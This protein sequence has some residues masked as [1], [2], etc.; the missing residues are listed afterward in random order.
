MF[1]KLTIVCS[2]ALVFISCEDATVFSESKNVD[3]EAWFY[4][5]GVTFS[6]TIEETEKPYRVSVWVRHDKNYKFSNIWLKIISDE[7]LLDG[8]LNL[9]ELKL[10]DN[11]GRWIGDCSRSL[12]TKKIVLREEHQ[13]TNA[14]SFK[15]EVFQ[16]MREEELIGV[17]SI[18]LLIEDVN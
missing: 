10:A 15:V 11:S 1:Q 6:P 14:E 4:Q 3:R 8:K 16:N 2:I 9:V 5:D 18:G 12:C 7:D 17:N 13:F